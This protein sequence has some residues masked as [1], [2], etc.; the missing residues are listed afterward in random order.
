MVSAAEFI[1]AIQRRLRLYRPR[2]VPPGAF[3]PGWQAWFASML[4]RQGAVTGALSSAI[5]DALLQRPLARPPRRADE[6]TRWQAFASLWRQQWHPPEREDRRVRWFAAAVSA[7]IHVLFA[8]MLLWLMYLQYIGNEALPEGEDVVQIEFIGTGT[9]EE[10]GAGPQA[11]PQPPAPQAGEAPSAGATTGAQ[12][13]SP[14]AAS[15]SVA[16]PS[17]ATPT[18]DAP[19]PDV[20]QRDVPE[21][22]LPP[23]QAEQRVTVSQ[24]PPDTTAVF[25]LPPTT[26]IAQRAESP[27]L[28]AP[29]ASV[30]ARE[31]PEPLQR[32]NPNAPRPQPSLSTA[33]TPALVAPQAQV[34]QRDVPT[35]LAR[36]AVPVLEATPQ[37]APVLQAGT[38]Q[39][40]TRDVPAPSSASPSPSQ[41]AAATT[42]SSTAATASPA[43]STAAAST[44]A[45]SAAPT[46]GNPSPATAGARAPGA[47]ATTS[48]TPGRTAGQGPKPAAS[49]GG[50]P[51]PKRGDDWGDSTRNVPGGQR[52]DPAGLY[53]A[54]GSVRLGEPPG[55]A[56]PGFPPGTISEEIANLD[57]S[58]TWLKRRPTDYEPT[59]FDQ[60]WRP[61]ENLLEEW[62]R[63]GV[64]SVEVPIP[65][66]SKK[67][68]CAVSLLQLG[69]GCRV[70]DPNLNDQPATARP[71][72]DI[73]FKPELQEGNGSR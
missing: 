26:P 40:R 33:D 54:D 5:V 3:P 1:E 56:S 4:E 15:A 11:G 25:V 45:A 51:S 34:S 68:V 19:I 48:P 32:L 63:R 65:G 37:A 50:W 43:A 30:A 44:A 47:A 58:G 61:H 72:P 52:G 49:V 23:V 71:P 22:Q 9:P 67:L 46:T 16:P 41:A 13:P 24:S 39:T 28:A 66:T 18:L 6:L 7:I 36:V 57:R 29:S 10:A 8:A 17:V 60:Y 55:S 2:P 35:P 27:E 14:A 21:P 31:V 53:N 42:A 62:V 69:G 38:A 12:P 70:A 73:P 20:P 64:K 59:A